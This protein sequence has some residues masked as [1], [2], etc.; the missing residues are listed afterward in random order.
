VTAIL[1]AANGDEQQLTAYSATV[2][3]SVPK[4]PVEV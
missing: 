1:A 3:C 4:L 2:C